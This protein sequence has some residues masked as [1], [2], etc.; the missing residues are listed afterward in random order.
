ML[1]ILIILIPTLLKIKMDFFMPMICKW[2][3]I[4]CYNEPF[5]IY[6]STKTKSFLSL[7]GHCT[8]WYIG[9]VC[10][11]NGVSMDIYRWDI[12]R[13]VYKGESLVWLLECP[14]TER[15]ACINFH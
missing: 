3:S 5:L 7:S 4:Q 13:S 14:K 11:S 8:I 2:I 12:Q 6:T 15:I 10:Q 9:R 1:Y